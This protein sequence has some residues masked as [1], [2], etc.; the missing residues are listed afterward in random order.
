MYLYVCM[1]VYS[2]LYFWSEATGLLT[3]L[4]VEPVNNFHG[5]NFQWKTKRE[6]EIYSRFL[7]QTSLLI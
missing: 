3:N 5:T 4:Q 6:V 1:Y 7:T 2:C